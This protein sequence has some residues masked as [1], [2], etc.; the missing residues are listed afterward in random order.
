MPQDHEY[1]KKE[2]KNGMDN[3]EKDVESV[4]NRTCLETRYYKI[5]NLDEDI[6]NMN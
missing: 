3:I 2:K 4:E 5:I 6:L 1:S